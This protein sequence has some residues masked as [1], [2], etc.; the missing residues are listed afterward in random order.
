[1]PD[2]FFTDPVNR[3]PGNQQKR[4]PR[5]YPAHSPDDWFGKPATQPARTSPRGPHAGAVLL[6]LAGVLFF[7]NNT[8]IIHIGSIFEYWPLILIAVGVSR[9]KCSRG[10][11][12]VWSLAMIAMGGIF[13]TRN[14]GLLYISFDMVWPIALIGAGVLLLVGRMEA[15]AIFRFPRAMPHATVGHDDRRVHLF[16]FFGGVKRVM[17]TDDFRGG[18]ALAIFGGVDLDLRLARMSGAVREVVVE[19]DA[20]FGGVN[21][22]VPDNWRVAVRGVGLFGGY[23]DKTLRRKSDVNPDGPLLVVTGYAAFGGIEVQS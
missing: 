20:L 1:M 2:D 5:E 4:D 18:E 3:D 13:L 14:L 11:T 9:F 10:P 7:L 19:A 15:G 16:S 22:K 12:R 8:G 17:D 21:I 23:V 6:I